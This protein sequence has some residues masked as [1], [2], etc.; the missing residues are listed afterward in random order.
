MVF[1][2]ILN[3]LL[4]D[5]GFLERQNKE[6]RKV[7]VIDFLLVLLQIMKMEKQ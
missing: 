2:L 7:R 5:L 1:H 6:V 4:C 3:L